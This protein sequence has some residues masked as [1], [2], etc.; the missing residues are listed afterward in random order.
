M[1]QRPIQDLIDGIA[2]LG[3]KI[4]GRK[5]FPPVF[6]SGNNTITTKYVYMKG[7]SSSQYF[8]ALL[9]VAPL[10]PQGLHIEVE[11]E[12][13]SKP[14]IDMT[15]YEM[16]KFCVEVQNNDYRSFDIIP[17]TYKPQDLTVEGD[18]SALSYFAAY[19]CLHGGELTIT[20][21]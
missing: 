21:I 18:A 4:K 3:I 17:Q 6:I 14:Y 20:N 12:L 9:Q 1:R 16:K 15:I 7:A 2:Q 19:F 5:G 10:F 8:T 11:G 13:V